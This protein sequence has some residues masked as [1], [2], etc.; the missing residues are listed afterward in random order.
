M[1]VSSYVLRCRSKDQT[2]ILA[3][4]ENLGEFQIGERSEDGM[5]I[6]VGTEDNAESEAMGHALSELPGVRGA[7]LVYHSMED[8]TGARREA[9]VGAQ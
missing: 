7:I 9:P 8:L 4:L 6:A 1:P 3:S 2:D 5:A